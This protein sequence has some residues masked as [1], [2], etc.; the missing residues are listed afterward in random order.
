VCCDVAWALGINGLDV[1]PG[2]SGTV[3]FTIGDTAPCDPSSASCFYIQQTNTDT[4]N[5]IYLSADVTIVPPSV[6]GVPEPS[7]FVLGLG[8]L[9]VA[10][11]GMRAKRARA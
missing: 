8:I 2:G 3:T 6:G 11:I 4:S 5:S 1:L 10:A 9:G 7:T